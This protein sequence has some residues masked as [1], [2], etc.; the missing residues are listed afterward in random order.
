MA[1]ANAYN[2]DTLVNKEFGIQVADGLTSVDARILPA[3]MVIMC[4]FVLFVTDNG[5][6]NLLMLNFTSCNAAA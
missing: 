1:R 5:T 2:E 6:S 3:P 4:R